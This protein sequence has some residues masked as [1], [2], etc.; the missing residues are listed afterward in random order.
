L[1]ER[2]RGQ[3]I[4]YVFDLLHLDGRDLTQ[5]PL[6]DRKTSLAGLIDE[7][8][9]P[10]SVIRYSMHFASDGEEVLR[11]ACRMGLEGIISKRRD[12]PYQP[13]RSRNWLKIKCVKRQEFV[14][15]GFTDPEGSRTGIGALLVGVNE[16]GHL[17][18]AGKV[19]TGFSA[20]TL[21]DLRTRLRVLEQNECP[22]SPRLTG[23]VTR[24]SHWV[25]PELAAEVAFTEWTA[26]GKIRHPSFQGLRR[27]K[28]ASEIVREEPLEL[29]EVRRASRSKLDH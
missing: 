19:G 2:G 9:V 13:G 12:L 21:T 17:R 3:L 27:D 10:D 1:K 22:F 5:L 8:S 24:G 14:I 7:L 25:K 28:P 20:D 11:K 4:Y 23:A 18:F 29:P 26:D 16:S 6:E 15:G